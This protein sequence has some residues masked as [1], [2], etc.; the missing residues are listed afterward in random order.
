LETILVVDDHAG[1]LQF[2]SL[3]LRTAQFDVIEATGAEDAM[4]VAAAHVGVI[5][6]LLS[7]VTLGPALGTGLFFDAA[8]EPPAD[9]ETETDSGPDLGVR[10]KLV[11]PQLK[12]MLMSGGAADGS[13]L[14]LNYGWAYIRKPF[15][16]TKLVEMVTSVLRTPDRSQPA[17]AAAAGFDSREDNGDKKPDVTQ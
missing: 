9:T 6:M 13:L 14:V 8:P 17:T 4:R 7:D 16:A 3:I 15:I 5:D 10:L 2:V 1:V 12:V 11:R